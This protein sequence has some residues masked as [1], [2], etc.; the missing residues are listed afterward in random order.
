MRQGNIWEYKVSCVQTVA[1]D[2][3]SVTTTQL[4]DLMC[5]KQNQ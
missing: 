3:D 5:L 4:Q 1:F 2:I